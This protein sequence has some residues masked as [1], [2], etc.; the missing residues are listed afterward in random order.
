MVKTQVESLGGKIAIESIVN[1]GTTFTIEF[2][3]EK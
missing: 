3:R 2:E 1:Q